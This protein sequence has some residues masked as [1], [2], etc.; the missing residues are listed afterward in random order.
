[1]PIP[2]FSPIIIAII[3]GNNDVVQALVRRNA[4]INYGGYKQNYIP[5]NLSIKHLNWI[6]C[7]KLTKGKLNYNQKDKLL[8]IPLHKL[9]TASLINDI[10]PKLIE[11]FI[12]HSDILTTN[13]KKVS[14]L[15]LL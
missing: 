8:E 12:V 11:K 1:N 10:S 15:Q 5:V 9:I 4:D 14:C 6:V 7:D 3:K 2:F 13:I